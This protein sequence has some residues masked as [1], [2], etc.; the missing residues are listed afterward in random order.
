M[1]PNQRIAQRLVA[2]IAP[3]VAAPA[4]AVAPAM[5][6]TLA[7]SEA[8]FQFDNFSHSAYSV[9]AATNTNTLTVVTGPGSSTTAT[10]EALA[11]FVPGTAGNFSSSTASGQ[12][13]SYFGV[14]QS[15]AQ[16]IGN[17]LVGPGES[18][19]FNFNASLALKSAVDNP[20]QEMASAAGRT[21]FFLF[22]ST[23]GGP[24][25]LL[26]SFS[27]FGQVTTPGNN[28]LDWQ[29]SD[30][31]NYTSESSLNYTDTESLALAA[32]EGWYQ[33]SFDS[34]IQLTLVE[35]K[36]NQ[37]QVQVPE[38]SVRL[39]LPFLLLLMWVGRKV[40]RRSTIFGQLQIAANGEDSSR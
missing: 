14:A 31:I 3:I 15:M 28:F 23:D 13:S 18:F 35:F 37:A 32:F 29:S 17:F 11:Y 27:V 40:S 38:P 22:G 21:A 10:A 30:N 33:R 20:Q 1:K 12:G 8:T 36:E 34:Q 16:I 7:S 9:G 2:L 26:D 5:A 25:S 39:A 19:G 6:A 24:A 4:I